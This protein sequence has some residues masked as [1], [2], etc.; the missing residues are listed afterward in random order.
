MEALYSPL[1][2]RAEPRDLRFCEF[3]LEMFFEDAIWALRPVGPIAKRS[4][5]GRTNSPRLSERRRRGTLSP[6]PAS[7]LCRKTFPG[8]VRGTVDPSASLP[9]NRFVSYA[10]Q[11]GCSWVRTSENPKDSA[12]FRKYP[13]FI[14]FITSPAAR[15]SARDDKGEG[16]AS[17]ERGCWTEG[18]FVSLGGPQAHDSS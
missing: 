11:A 7:V 16:D 15:S 2:S 14:G 10:K 6:Q 4:P 1:S 12:C 18:V 3:V 13:L 8:M 17:M 5:A 9:M